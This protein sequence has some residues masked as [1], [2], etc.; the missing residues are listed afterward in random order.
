[1]DEAD[2]LLEMQF[3]GAINKLLAVVPKERNTYLYSATMTKE[4]SKLQ[5]ASLRNPAKAE[6]SESYSTVDTL[7]QV[8]RD[9]VLKSLSNDNCSNTY[10]FHKNTK[11]VIQPTC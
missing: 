8:Y 4:V 9:F 2:R 10:L 5:R 6:V 7:T 11:T 3:E 1:M